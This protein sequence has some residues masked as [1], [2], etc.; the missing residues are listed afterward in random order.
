MSA[1]SGRKQPQ[2]RVGVDVLFLDRF[3]RIA[4]NRRFRQML[5]TERE[6]AAV[7]DTP[8]RAEEYLA[9]RFAAKEA[10]AKV[11]GIG[12]LEGLV[13][14]DIEVTRAGAA[15]EVVLHAGAMAAADRHGLAGI[16][17]SITHQG[18]LVVSVAAAAHQE[19]E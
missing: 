18:P 8:R 16:S 12:F 2:V 14:R 17:V 5:F 11:L 1:A 13:W 6:L 10:V 15:P 3:R 9:G 19:N 4:A 7:P